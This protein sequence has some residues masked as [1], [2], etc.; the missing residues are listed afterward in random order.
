MRDL[1]AC[2]DRNA[3]KCSKVLPKVFP[4]KRGR[5]NLGCRGYCYIPTRI[6]GKIDKIDRMG[7]FLGVCKG[8]VPDL[9]GGGDRVK[10][11]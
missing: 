11:L 6:I 4:F 3:A 10:Y 1:V 5:G 7:W 8:G 9:I 2:N